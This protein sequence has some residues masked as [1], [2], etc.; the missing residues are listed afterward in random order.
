MIPYQHIHNCFSGVSQLILV[1]LFGGDTKI[2]LVDDSALYRDGMRYVLNRLDNQVDILE[3]ENLPDALNAS[4]DNLDID[5]VLLDLN[6]PGCE[7]VDSMKAF[8]KYHPNLPVVVISSTDHLE[9]IE[10]VMLE[11]AKGF[12]SKMTSGAD[13]MHALRRVL[14]GS[15]HLSHQLL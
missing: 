12:I 10:M 1:P 14:D 13:M 4:R 11:G 2:L 8:H 5:L 7:G 9:N 6:M 15:V 3:A